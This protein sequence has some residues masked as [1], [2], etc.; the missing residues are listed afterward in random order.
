MHTH[1]IGVGSWRE[2][3]APSATRLVDFAHLGE[4]YLQEGIWNGRRLVPEGWVELA[5]APNAPFQ[6]PTSELPG[7]AMQFWIPPGYDGEFYGAGAFGQYL[8]IDTRREVVVA[9]FA[10]QAPGDAE[11]GE[12]DA[13][14]RALVSAIRSP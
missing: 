7:Y 4:L 13:A 11:R 9:Q 6:E 3:S 5:G 12:R 8:W 10:A 14:F 1:S 2:D